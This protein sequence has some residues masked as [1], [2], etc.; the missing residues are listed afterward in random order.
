MPEI[1]NADLS[2]SSH[3]EILINLLD[4]YAQDPMGGGK[5][6]SEYVKTNLVSSLREKAGIHV[7]FA[8]SNGEAAGLLIAMEGFS[9]FA[10]QPL[11]NIH[12]VVVVPEYRGQGIAALMLQAAEKIALQIGCCKLT[13]EVLEGNAVAKSVYARFGFGGYQLDPKMGNALFLEKKI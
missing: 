7:I 11:L 5:G 12:D 3:S 13:L 10:C 4:I 9:T 6:L 2:N 1:I 8:F